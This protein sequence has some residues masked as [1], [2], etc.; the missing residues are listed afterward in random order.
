MLKR[1]SYLAFIFMPV[2]I[3]LPAVLNAEEWKK[4]KGVSTLKV[5]ILGKGK[6]HYGDHRTEDITKN[7]FSCG[8]MLVFPV[9]RRLYIGPS[10]DLYMADSARYNGSDE[11]VLDFAFN[12]RAKFKTG[13]PKIFLWP[14]A[15]I[16]YAFPKDKEEFDNAHGTTIKIFCDFVYQAFDKAGL[17][18][19]IGGAY[20]PYVDYSIKDITAGPLLTLRGGFQF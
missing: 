6:I 5:G 12:M 15:S 19:E 7:S 20:S 14:T 8:F 2:I 9:Y 17:L 4:P 10:I 1:F 13:N 3:F 18:V 16:G 11:P